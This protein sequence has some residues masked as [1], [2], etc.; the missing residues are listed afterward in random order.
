MLKKI[1][2]LY[3]KLSAHPKWGPLL[4]FAKFAMVGVSNMLVD[5][6]VYYLTILINPKLYLLGKILGFVISVLNSYYWNNRFV[7]LTR[8]TGTRKEQFLRL[9]RTYLSYGTTFLLSLFLLWLEVEKLGISEF[10]AP[11]INLILVPLNF[12]FNKLWA[13]KK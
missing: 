13:F 9:G 1:R 2:E 7:F 5:N 6:A 4:Q 3:R 11:I 8:G 12:L 10:I